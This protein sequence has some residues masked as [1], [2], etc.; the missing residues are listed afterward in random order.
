MVG[1]VLVVFRTPVTV[2]LLSFGTVDIRLATGFAVFTLVVVFVVAVTVVDL[3]ATVPTVLNLLVIAFELDLVVIVLVVV[4]DET[5]LL[6]VD[7][8]V[9]GLA[10]GT[11]DEERTVVV[12]PDVA[13][14][15]VGDFVVAVDGFAVVDLTDVLDGLALLALALLAELLAIVVDL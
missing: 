9:R 14:A 12:V 15:A 4:V 2:V 8:T 5:V 13:K 3:G 6:D 10:V 1:V 7:G 11:V